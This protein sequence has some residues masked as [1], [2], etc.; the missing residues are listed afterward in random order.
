MRNA[1]MTGAVTLVG[2]GLVLIGTSGEHE[3]G[4]AFASTSPV[5]SRHLDSGDCKNADPDE[6]WFSNRA[7]YIEPIPGNPCPG[8]P[9]IGRPQP[10]G[11]YLEQT[12]S[13]HNDTVDLNLDGRQEVS[14]AGELRWENGK[15]NYDSQG[16]FGTMAYLDYTDGVTMA[17]FI[18]I[19][20]IKAIPA[21]PD[22]DADGDPGSV[23]ISRAHVR[24]YFDVDGDG[25][26]DAIIQVG[27][28]E[29]DLWDDEGCSDYLWTVDYYWLKNITSTDDPLAA[30]LNHDGSVNGEDL[31]ILLASWTGV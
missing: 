27:S 19:I 5:P 10:G 11:S 29:C 31:G 16:T 8:W 30:D 9:F 15:W 13:Q 28:R 26:Q 6:A 4:R 24:G 23:A 3:P 18:R 12:G 7:N 1:C 25:K 20:D 2:F 22:P 17:R 21:P 14:I